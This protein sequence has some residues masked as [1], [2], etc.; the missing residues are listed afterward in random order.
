IA[1][2]LRPGGIL[3]YK[4]YTSE[5]QNLS[6]GP[7]HPMHLLQSGELQRAFAD[8]EILHYSETVADKAVAELV[9][10]KA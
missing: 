1:A 9:A 8:L 7:T 5:Q 4:T 6:R 2:A 3:I 10:R